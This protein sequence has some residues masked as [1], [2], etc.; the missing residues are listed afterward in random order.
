MSVF[1]KLHHRVHSCVHLG[2]FDC[3]HKGV[4]GVRCYSQTVHCVY[5]YS[6]LCVF[7]VILL[8]LKVFMTP[9]PGGCT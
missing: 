2:L 6:T 1:A 9:V 7:T 4:L 5:N 3:V 8:C